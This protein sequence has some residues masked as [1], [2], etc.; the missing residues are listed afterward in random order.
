MHRNG[1][2]AEKEKKNDNTTEYK[3]ED[4]I[5]LS[6]PSKRPVSR[7]YDYLPKPIL[8]M[9]EETTKK[10]VEE[11]KA[12]NTGLAVGHVKISYMLM[13]C[14][15]A[16][17]HRADVEEHTWITHGMEMHQVKREVKIKVNEAE[18]LELTAAMNFKE[19]SK[20]GRLEVYDSWFALC[21]ASATSFEYKI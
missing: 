1:D 8:D 11:F 17:D 15:L 5:K 18:A 7:F 13:R 21:V 2:T 20:Q 14:D 9:K 19:L 12:K 16:M 6:E 4:R 3:G 10:F